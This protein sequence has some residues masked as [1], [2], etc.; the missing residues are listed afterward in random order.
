MEFGYGVWI[1]PPWNWYGV[2]VLPFGGVGSCVGRGIL[3]RGCLVLM[4]VFGD[5]VII[6]DVVVEVEVV[7]GRHDIV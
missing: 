6:G 7:I 3:L 5:I 2:V 4:V 1:E